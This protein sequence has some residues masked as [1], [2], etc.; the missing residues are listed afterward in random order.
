MSSRYW[1][2]FWAWDW[3]RRAAADV[4]DW[5]SEAVG[6]AEGRE[7]SDWGKEDVADILEKVT[8]ALL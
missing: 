4:R 2:E 5:S 7:T 3:A 1:A 6:R 8:V